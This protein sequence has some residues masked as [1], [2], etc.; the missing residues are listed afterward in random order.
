MSVVCLYQ[1][2]TTSF[3]PSLSLLIFCHSV[4]CCVYVAL[5]VQ[6]A[7]PFAK[8]HL[9]WSQ[10]DRGRA[11]DL[12]FSAAQWQAMK[13]KGMQQKGGPQKSE[14][15]T[16]FYDININFMTGRKSKRSLAKGNQ[17]YVLAKIATTTITSAAN[18]NK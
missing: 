10:I 2:A 5:P 16:K 18:N 9:V 1:R 6:I 15:R 11:G 8:L 14:N 12:D 3:F 7:K 4:A 13:S 17:F